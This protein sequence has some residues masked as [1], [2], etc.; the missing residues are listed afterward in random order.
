MTAAKRLTLGTSAGVK[1]KRLAALLAGRDARLPAVERALVEAQVRGS[2]ELA[3]LGGESEADA[4]R[5]AIA[6]VDSKAPL[7]GL[8]EEAAARA[9][10]VS[11]AALEAEGPR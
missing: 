9:L 10:D 2:L 7:A 6:A 1:E 4:L 3:G 5:R 8:L 11:I